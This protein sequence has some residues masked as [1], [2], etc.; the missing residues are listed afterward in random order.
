MDRR[1]TFLWMRDILDHLS[2]CCEQWES[3]DASSERFLADAMRRDMD[4]L[5]KLYQSVRQTSRR[6]TAAFV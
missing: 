1:S 6:Q 4:E 5:R 3:A 2:S